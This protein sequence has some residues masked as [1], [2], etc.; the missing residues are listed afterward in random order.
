M[1][2][3]AWHTGMNGCP[4]LEE[5]EEAILKVAFEN[6][7]FET[8]KDIIRTTSNTSLNDLANLLISKPSY[9]LRIAGHTD[10]VGEIFDAKEK[11][12][13]VLSIES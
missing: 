10:N 2:E 3:Y 8:G 12:V 11:S 4:K 5:K 6:L 13:I 1:S 9:G 7:E